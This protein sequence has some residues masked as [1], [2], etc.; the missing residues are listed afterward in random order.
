MLTPEDAN[1]EISMA[2]SGEY[3]VD[4]FSRP[5]VAPVALLRDRNGHLL[6]TLER[7][8]ISKLVSLGWKPPLSIMVKARDGM[9]NLYGLMFKPTSFDP[10]NKYPIIDF[11]YPGPQ[12]GSVG[13]RHFVASRSDRQ[14]LAELGF[15]VVAIDGM[16]TPLRSKEFHDAYYGD[17]RDNTLPDQVAAIKQLA[18]RYPWIDL[19]RSASMDI[20]AAAMPRLG[21]C[22]DIPIF[23]KWR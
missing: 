12:L 5:D 13:S 14:S 20:P 18:Q 22:S 17:M 1:H 10:S 3:F 11:I 6:S 2:P 21:Q 23:L 4:R 9:T 19:S 16:G 7:A 15:I 8:D